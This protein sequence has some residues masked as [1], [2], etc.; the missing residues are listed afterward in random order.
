MAP[1]VGLRV[2]AQCQLE[3]S[4]KQSLCWTCGAQ[5]DSI[6]VLDPD[7][8]GGHQA[9]D[10]FLRETKLN[11]LVVDET[12]APG[13]SP[14]VFTPVNLTTTSHLPLC[15]SLKCFS[16]DRVE[17]LYFHRQQDDFKAYSKIQ[18]DNHLFKKEN[19]PRILKFKEYCP[20]LFRNL[21]ERFGIDD[22]DY[23][24]TVIRPSQ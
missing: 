22:Q 2:A 9:Q 19:L 1:S 7:P 11:H 24:N 20:M 12:V 6:T 8:P 4:Q 14:F 16:R 21:Q 18:V 10:S 17:E 15:R 3:H 23:Q 5:G 13:G